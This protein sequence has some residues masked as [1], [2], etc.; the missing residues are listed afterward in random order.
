MGFKAQNTVLNPK[1]QCAAE[2]TRQLIATSKG[3]QRVCPDKKQA[4]DPLNCSVLLTPPEM[5]I[6][7]KTCG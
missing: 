7:D 5:K 2:R 4:F 3:G 1:R 6:G